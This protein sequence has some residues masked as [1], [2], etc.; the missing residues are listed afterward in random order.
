MKLKFVG[1]I[2]PLIAV[3]CLSGCMST[4]PHLKSSI[5]EGVAGL[6]ARLPY[7]DYVNYFG[8]VDSNMK[9]QGKYKGKDVCHME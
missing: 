8:Y 6:E 4:G 1:K 2:L 3:A 5:S 7:A 9:S